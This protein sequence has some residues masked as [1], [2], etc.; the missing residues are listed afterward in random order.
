[1]PKSY[2]TEKRLDGLPLE[3]TKRISFGDFGRIE[4]DLDFIGVVPG[5]D[6]WRSALSRLFAGAELIHYPAKQA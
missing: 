2:R 4:D 5:C 6:R 1:M 3:G